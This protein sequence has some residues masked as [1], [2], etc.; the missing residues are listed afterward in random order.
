[1][2][3]VPHL[4][5]TIVSR[6]CHKEESQK[7]KL[8]LNSSQFRVFRRSS[9]FDPQKNGSVLDEVKNFLERLKVH[10]T[11]SEEFFRQLRCRWFE[12]KFLFEEQEKN[13]AMFFQTHSWCEEFLLFLLL[14]SMFH[15]KSE[16][17][18]E[19]L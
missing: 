9:L 13:R 16:V 8:L 5:P 11:S 6:N 7:P 1:M 14:Q 4:G 12:K 17:F 2:F 3:L 19:R 10:L 15:R 18:H